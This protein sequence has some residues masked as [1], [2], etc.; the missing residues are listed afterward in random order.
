MDVDFIQCVTGCL[1]VCRSSVYSALSLHSQLQRPRGGSSSLQTLVILLLHLHFLLLNVQTL[2]CHREQPTS[3]T[4][5][6]SGPHYRRPVGFKR[7]QC[8]N[9]SSGLRG[10]VAK[11]QHSF[12]VFSRE[13]YINIKIYVRTQLCEI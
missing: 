11:S 10:H 4:I 7:S 8:F 2:S 3:P 12:C 1:V 13:I 5:P 9:P 6:C